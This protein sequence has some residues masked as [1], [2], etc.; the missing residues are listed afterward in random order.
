M[1]ADPRL[2]QIVPLA[3]GEKPAPGAIAHGAGLDLILDHLNGRAD[4]DAAIAKAAAAEARAEEAIRTHNKTLAAV[5]DEMSGR[6]GD[7]EAR[8]M[9]LRKSAAGAGPHRRAFI[10]CLAL[11][12]RHRCQPQIRSVRKWGQPLAGGKNRHRLFGR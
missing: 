4:L 2:F 3:A 5:L 1:T 8:I 11:A 12:R 9:G 6:I 7:F 10:R